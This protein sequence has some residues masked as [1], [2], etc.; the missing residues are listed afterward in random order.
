MIAFTKDIGYFCSCIVVFS[1]FLSR[2]SVTFSFSRVVHILFP[3]E[4]GIF[5]KQCRGLVD[6]NGKYRFVCRFVVNTHFTQ[7]FII[8]SKKD[9]LV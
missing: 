8:V 9:S 6:V 1:V 7:F 3:R 4:N 5:V 2:F